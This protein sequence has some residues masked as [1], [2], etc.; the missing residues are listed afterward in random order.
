MSVKGG[1]IRRGDPLSSFLPAQW[2]RGPVVP[3]DDLDIDEVAQAVVSAAYFT[4]RGDPGLRHQMMTLSRIH[5]AVTLVACYADRVCPGD[6]PWSAGDIISAAA[7]RAYL[8]T[9]SIARSRLC[10]RGVH[11]AVVAILESRSEDAAKAL[12]ADIILLVLEVIP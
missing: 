1:T 2:A 6:R 4:G 10:G 7:A 8:T 12:A 5:V 9:T 11:E 3:S